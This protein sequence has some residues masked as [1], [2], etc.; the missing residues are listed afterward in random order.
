M[1]E[2]KYNVYK[3]IPQNAYSGGMVL[4]SAENESNAVE[5][6][7]KIENELNDYYWHLKLGNIS[8]IE[9]LSYGVN[10]VLID[11]DIY[12]E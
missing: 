1:E 5:V 9:G 10:G 4:F 8:Q 11:Y 6:L 3:A 12:I 2:M 7:K